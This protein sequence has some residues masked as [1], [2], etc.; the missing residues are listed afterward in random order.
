MGYRTCCYSYKPK[1]SFCTQSVAR[2]T[3]L[4]SAII[5]SHS[6]SPVRLQKFKGC[7]RG[8]I[9]SPDGYQI[10]CSEQKQFQILWEVWNA[11]VGLKLSSRRSVKQ[12]LYMFACN[13][14]SSHCRPFLTFA[15]KMCMFFKFYC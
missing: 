12:R 4:T 3:G 14:E 2:N 5:Y 15:T 6:A 13:L 11:Q 1:E 7:L 9:S 8:P 10:I